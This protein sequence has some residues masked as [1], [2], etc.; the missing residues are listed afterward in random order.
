MLQPDDIFLSFFE[1]RGPLASTWKSYPH[2]YKFVGVDLSV[3]TDLL[4]VERQTY[5]ALEFVGD[6]GGLLDAVMV[7][8]YIVT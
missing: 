1:E 6:L 4:V 5:S 8:G 3:S 2:K 7:L